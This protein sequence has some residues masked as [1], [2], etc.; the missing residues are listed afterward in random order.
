MAKVQQPAYGTVKLLGVPV[1]P[2]KEAV[3]IL[4]ELAHVAK[5]TASVINVLLD[6]LVMADVVKALK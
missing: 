4:D 2:E 6:W 5:L 3:I 1:V